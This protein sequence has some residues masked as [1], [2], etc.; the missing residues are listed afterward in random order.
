MKTEDQSRRARLAT[1]TALFAAAT[2]GIAVAMI[3]TF[4]ATADLPR[5]FWTPV[6]A[7]ELA[8]SEDDLD[9]L[10]GTDAEAARLRGQMDAGHRWDMAFPVAYG[11]F[12]TLILLQLAF[13]RER[14]MWLGVPVALA[15]IPADIREN[16]VLLD[17]TATLEQGRSAAD[18]L[19]ALDAAT[20][21]KWG[22]LA[23]AMG[24][25]GIGLLRR[26]ARLTG[27]LGAVGAG[28]IGLTWLTNSHAGIAEAMAVVVFAFFL[29]NAARSF[30]AVWRLRGAGRR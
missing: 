15:T 26:G 29:A 25:S 19:P 28:A 21:A 5:G 17:I 20:W 2:I 22:A 6:L 30:A 8:R 11:G 12:L 3:M 24:W 9:F 10:A 13:D 7:F 18:L 14:L 27:G 16:L 4:P 1:T 23:V